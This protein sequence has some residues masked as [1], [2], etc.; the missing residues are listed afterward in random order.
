MAYRQY[1]RGV[2]DGRVAGFLGMQQSVLQTRLY[3]SFCSCLSVSAGEQWQHYQQAVCPGNTSTMTSTDVTRSC[4]GVSGDARNS[5][6]RDCQDSK[7]HLCSQG[8]IPRRGLWHC[9]K[10][11][12][13]T[14][15]AYHYVTDYRIEYTCNPGYQLVGGKTGNVVG[16]LCS[17]RAWY[18]PTSLSCKGNALGVHILDQ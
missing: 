4:T 13:I 12:D 2:D 1:L 8:D 17:D 6:Q 7:V 14:N 15:G 5:S 10:P 18:P 11:E 16:R 9:P 3:Y